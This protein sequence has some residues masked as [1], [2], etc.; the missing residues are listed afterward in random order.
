MLAPEPD[1]VNDV[2]AQTKD[3]LAIIDIGGAGL[4]NTIA[5]ADELQPFASEP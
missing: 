3:E 4:V 2:D 1:K 5:L